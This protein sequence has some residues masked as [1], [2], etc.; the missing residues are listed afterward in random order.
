MGRDTPTARR[1]GSSLRAR[2]R[3][4]LS[5]LAVLREAAGVSLVLFRIMVPVLVVVKLLQEI[6]A[7]RYLGI[8]LGPV[9]RLVGLPGSMGLVWATAMVTN[10][11]GGMAVFLSLL[12]DYPL[13]VAQVTVLTTMILIAHSMPVEL[14]IARKSGAR[15]RFTAPFRILNAFLLG[16]LLNLIYAAGSWLQGSSTPVW[17]T[18]VH[19]DSLSAWGLGQ[20]ENM[21]MIFLIVLGLLVLMRVLRTVGAADAMNRPLGPVLTSMGIGRDAATITVF[22]LVLG[23]SYGGGL[24]IRAANSGEIRQRDTFFAITLMTLCHSLVED[25]LLMLSLGADLT[26]LLLARMAFTWVMMTILVRIVSQMPDHVFHRYLFRSRRTRPVGNV[27]A[28]AG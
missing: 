18:P 10:I 27:R 7:I 9:M 15:L 6:G 2:A 12:P 19:D 14:S 20:L 4:N 8:A 3:Q 28:G 21:L 17:K 26:G 25:T 13:T 11:Y 16:A 23:I 5:P 1:D 22:G 24:I